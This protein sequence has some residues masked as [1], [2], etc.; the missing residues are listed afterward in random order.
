M[1]GA[2]R[3]QLRAA[4]EQL[5][6]SLVA[7]G[8]APPGFSEK[9]VATQAEMLLAKRQRI[10]AKLQPDLVA[11]LG[12]RF[13]PLFRDFARKHARSTGTTA[14]DDGVAFR[15]WLVERNEIAAQGNRVIAW[16]RRMRHS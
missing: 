8:P 15:E 16:L 2:A 9:L 10:V 5:L 4:Q 6:R 13:T 14:R 1:T 12:E 7:D 11:E 3:E